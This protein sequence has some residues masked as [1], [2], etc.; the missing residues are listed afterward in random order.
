MGQVDAGWWRHLDPKEAEWVP[1]TTQVSGRALRP[2][3]ASPFIRV[4]KWDRDI[5][6]VVLSLSVKVACPGWGMDKAREM[7]CKKNILYTRFDLPVSYHLCKEITKIKLPPV[8]A[9][10]LDSGLTEE[11]QEVTGWLSPSGTRQAR[12]RLLCIH[13]R[14]DL[15]DVS[16]KYC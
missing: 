5:V 3:I 14:Q 1:K 10:Q 6:G 12:H 2:H 16:V 13:T 11:Q 15:Q 7:L 9:E 8:C 4:P